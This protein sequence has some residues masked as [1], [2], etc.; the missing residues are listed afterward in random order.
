[1]TDELTHLLQTD[2]VLKCLTLAHGLDPTNPHIGPAIAD[3]C[4]RAELYELAD[5]I[6]KR[7]GD[8]AAA[9]GT[10]AE[11]AGMTAVSPM[12]DGTVP[13]VPPGPG[14]A[15]TMDLIRAALETAAEQMEAVARRFARERGLTGRYAES[16]PRGWLT[17][18]GWSG[19][20]RPG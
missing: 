18:P 13:A 19:R 16:T 5:V 1:M 12:P 14:I 11:W 2:R 20:R 9:V 7:P 6:I 17:V 3:R 8:W 15:S 10:A 4:V